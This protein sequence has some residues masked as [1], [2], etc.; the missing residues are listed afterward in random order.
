MHGDALKTYRR[1]R[2]ETATT[3]KLVIMCYDAAIDDLEEAKELHLTGRTDPCFKKIRHAQ[4]V[5]TELLVG[6]DYDQGGEIATN[7]GKLYN[8]MIR[9]LIGINMRQDPVIFDKL[10]H[11]LSGLREAWE[12][13]SHMP[14]PEA[15]YHDAQSGIAV[16]G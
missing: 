7:L 14:P 1:T 3:L 13:I 5:I 6:L 10:I 16:T 11:L 12:K 4:D 8:F 15:V 2:V 9:S